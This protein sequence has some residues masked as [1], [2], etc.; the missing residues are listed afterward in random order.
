[1]PPPRQTVAPE[2]GEAK[3]NEAVALHQAGRLDEA[4]ALYRFLAGPF[5]DHPDLFNLRGLIAEA[6]EDFG[7]AAALFEQ[8]VRLRPDDPAYLFNHALALR[9]LERFEEALAAYDKAGALIPLSPAAHFHRS[10]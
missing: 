1:M 4:D 9:R 5:P 2:V 3:L 10:G 8:A 6:R 7:A